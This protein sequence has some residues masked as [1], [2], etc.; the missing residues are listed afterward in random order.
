MA[1]A[2]TTE[3]LEPITMNNESRIDSPPD[4]KMVWLITI[5]YKNELFKTMQEQYYRLAQE[6]YSKFI[7]MRLRFR[8][9]FVAG[10]TVNIDEPFDEGRDIVYVYQN[11]LHQFHLQSLLE[12]INELNLGRFNFK[13]NLCL[14]EINEDDNHETTDA[15]D[16]ATFTVKNETKCHGAMLIQRRINTYTDLPNMV[17]TANGEVDF[18]KAEPKWTYPMKTDDFPFAFFNQETDPWRPKLFRLPKTECTAQMPTM[19]KT[20]ID[21]FDFRQHIR[22]N[23]LPE[24]KD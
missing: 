18:L 7:N 11:E 13:S 24:F 2:T 6:K 10:K 3:A 8:D 9:D 5:Y 1:P 21:N 15:T 19:I 12:K 16:H 23:F 20:S 4:P 22:A 17:R 14:D